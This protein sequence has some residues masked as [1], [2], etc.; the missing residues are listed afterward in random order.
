MK[1]AIIV[2]SAANAHGYLT[3]IVHRM[4]HKKYD[5]AIYIGD[6]VVAPRT[7]GLDIFDDN[8]LYKQI[9]GDWGNKN[10]LSPEE[11]EI[12]LLNFFDG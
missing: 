4:L 2:Y 12:Y 9:A 6:N 11:Y 3:C 5:Y 10:D 7:G 8:I 1:N